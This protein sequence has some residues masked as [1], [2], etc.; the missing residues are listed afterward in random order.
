MIIMLNSA[1]M[2]S[3]PEIQLCSSHLTATTGDSVKF[4][5]SISPAVTGT[6]VGVGVKVYEPFNKSTDTE[7]DMTKVTDSVYELNYNVVGETS[8]KLKIIGNVFT[9][10][11]NGTPKDWLRS[12]IA[13]MTVIPKMDELLGIDIVPFRTINMFVKEERQINVIGMFDD[14]YKRYI[15]E[16]FMGT[17][18]AITG[19]PGIA[20]VNADGII[21]ALKEG[22][23]TLIV[24]NGDFTATVEMFIMPSFDNQ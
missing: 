14:G 6:I 16:G 9:A 22:N 18:Y 10:K 17:T 2:A 7:Y 4:T 5:I 11:E 21:K 19:D 3:E 12:N 1:A 13:E 23:G 20:S 24:R 8:G 15:N